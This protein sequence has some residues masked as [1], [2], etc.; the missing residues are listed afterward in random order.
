MSMEPTTKIAYIMSRFPK[1]TETFI[2][3]EIPALEKLGVPVE[4]YP[5][6]RT[7]QSVIHPEA[8]EVV[9]RAHF[10]AFRAIW[11]VGILRSVSFIHFCCAGKSALV[12]TFAAAPSA[13]SQ[14]CKLQYASK[15]AR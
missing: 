13:S 5:L 6:L 8:E 9:K 7:R 1:L 2:L 12:A 10:H 3:Y 11:R 15:S 4:V 14:R